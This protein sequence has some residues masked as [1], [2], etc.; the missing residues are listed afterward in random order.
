MC[1]CKVNVKYLHDAP[2]SKRES[3][4]IYLKVESIDKNSG[5]IPIQEG[6]GDEGSTSSCF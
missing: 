2:V 1:P 6:K 3:F 4:L 5:W